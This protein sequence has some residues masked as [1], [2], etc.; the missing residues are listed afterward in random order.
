M[1]KRISKNLGVYAGEAPPETRQLELDGYTVMRGVFTPGEVKDLRA[2]I[3]SVFATSAPEPVRADAFRYQMFNRGPHSQ[4]A[5]AHPVILAVIEP[6]IG[7]DCHV[8][9]NTA[10][11][12]A[13]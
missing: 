9:A 7:D 13:P 3:D 11:R 1:I 5:L 2:E 10:W 8:I 6:L 4:A 12:N